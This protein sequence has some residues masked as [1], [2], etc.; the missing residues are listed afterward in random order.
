MGDLSITALC[1]SLSAAPPAVSSQRRYVIASR[2]LTLSS[3]WKFEA[4]SSQVEHRP[5]AIPTGGC[6]LHD[7][8]CFC[9]QKEWIN[10]EIWHPNS[11]VS[12]QRLSTLRGA[13][14]GMFAGGTLFGLCLCARALAANMSLSSRQQHLTTL[15]LPARGWE[16]M[17]CC[18]ELAVYFIEQ[19][20]Y[21]YVVC[22]KIAKKHVVAI[23]CPNKGEETCN[24]R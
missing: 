4:Q 7:R 16:A 18:R 3:I 20:M 13:E 5:K 24:R 2:Y 8:F 10:G 15:K 9:W 21:M 23:E 6:C 22:T 11:F 14:E 19:I 1:L 17:K 12:P